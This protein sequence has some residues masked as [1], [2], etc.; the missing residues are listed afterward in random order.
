MTSARLD[1]TRRTIDNGTDR[2]GA[3]IVRE[4]LGGERQPPPDPGLHPAELVHAAARSVHVGEADGDVG[5]L[6][7][8]PAEDETYAALY[9]LRQGLGDF[10]ASGLQDQVHGGLLGYGEESTSCVSS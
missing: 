8:E 6:P 1:E 2:G 7:A 9:V 3:H 4:A 5:D 10:H